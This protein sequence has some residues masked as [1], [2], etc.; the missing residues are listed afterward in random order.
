MSSGMR[1]DGAVRRLREADGMRS[2]EAGIPATKRRAQRTAQAPRATARRMG[3]RPAGRRKRRMRPEVT[4]ATD[5]AKH[6]E[7]TN[8]V[9]RSGLGLAPDDIL[10]YVERGEGQADA[11]NAKRREERQIGRMSVSHE[12]GKVKAKWVDRGRERKDAI[13]DLGT[14]P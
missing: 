4:N 1:R 2:E 13:L 10:A 5:L 12:R 7:Q 6:D 3:T 14:R 8:A 11:P 9:E